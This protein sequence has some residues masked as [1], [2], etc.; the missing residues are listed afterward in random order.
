M[1]VSPA[2]HI[3]IEDEAR[4]IARTDLTIHEIEGEAILFDPRTQDTHRFNA[5]AWLMFR[6]LDGIRTVKEIATLLTEQYDVTYHTA[7]TR[8]REFCILLD[9]LGLLQDQ[10]M[11]AWPVSGNAEALGET[12]AAFDNADSQPGSDRPAQGFEG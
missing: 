4:P 7:R 11:P 10:H 2:L 1:I 5:T 6:T 12:E 3:D 9:S 8:T